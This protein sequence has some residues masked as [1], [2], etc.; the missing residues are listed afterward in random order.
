MGKIEKVVVLSVLA[1]MVV[2]FVVLPTG[3][4]KTVEAGDKTARVEDTGG[5][6]RSN[7]PGDMGIMG[8]RQLSSKDDPKRSP[9]SMSKPDAG[10]VRLA[11]GPEGLLSAPV[12][13]G[14][15]N[16]KKAIKVQEPI[17]DHKTSTTN[18]LVKPKLHSVQEPAL[19]PTWSLVRVDGLEDTFNPAYK[20]FTCR[21]GDTFKGLAIRFYGDK[22]HEQFLRRNNESVR[23]LK[24]GQVVMMPCVN[25][26]PLGN[27]YTVCEGDSL[28]KISK[29]QYK[30]GYRWK[31]I[32]D[33]NRHVMKSPDDLSLGMELIIP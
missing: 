29:K 19:D 25:E 26:A 7:D 20:T 9:S 32:Y 17:A 2:I 3:S 23:R 13:I 8:P 1:L 33:A 18:G 14:S 10:Q 5:R 31:E 22:R 12:R 24:A 30:K 11:N 6:L 15:A 27:S 16:R 21:K 4:K 28:W